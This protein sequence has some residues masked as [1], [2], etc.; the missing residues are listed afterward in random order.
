MDTIFVT[1]KGQWIWMDEVTP[2]HLKADN[3]MKVK[4]GNGWRDSEVSKFVNE[5]LADFIAEDEE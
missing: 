5:Y 2:D 1:A 4:I 3:W